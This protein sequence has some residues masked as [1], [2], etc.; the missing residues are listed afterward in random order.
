MLATGR[1]GRGSTRPHN[2]PS[3]PLPADF[4]AATR[5]VE[6]LVDPPALPHSV[7][8]RR[9]LR[10]WRGAREAQPAGQPPIDT[11]RWRRI[12]RRTALFDGLGVAE[13]RQ[14][15]SLAGQFLASKAIT[16]AAD[17]TLS[18]HR[19][20]ALDGAVNGVPPLAAGRRQRW[21]DTFQSA[22]EQFRADLDAAPEPEPATD[23]DDA[24]LID[25]YAAESPDEFFAVTSEYHFCAPA[26]LHAAMPAVA[27]ELQAFYGDSPRA[28]RG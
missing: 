22:F 10:R 17:L 28:G 8:M 19:R 11:L 15:R 4:R 24:P 2:T 6:A 23:A 27:A 14:L 20:D 13:G 9:L 18:P 1:A 7:L 3:G 21:I 12:A 25:P 16:A 5:R 26:L